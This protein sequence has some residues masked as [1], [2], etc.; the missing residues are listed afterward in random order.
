MRQRRHHGDIG[1]GLQRQVML[2]LDMRR[3]HDVGAARIDHDQLGALPQ[4]LLQPR[5]EHR[6]PVGRVGADDHHDI[7]MIDAVE[8]LGAGRGAE[9]GLQAIAGRRMADARAGVDV[10]V[11]KTLP[12]QLLDEI[13]LLVGAAR[14]GDAADRAAAMLVLDAAELAGD[15]R[16]RFFPAHFAPRIAD[17]FPDHR[18]EDAILVVRIAPGETPLHAGMA[19]IGLAVLPGHHAHHFVAA[20]FRL[21]RAA[22]AAIGAGR[23]HRMG[24]PAL[25]RARIF[26]AARRS[27][28]PARRRRRTRIP[29]R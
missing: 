28:R 29:N 15:V 2:R 10:V 27:D 24:R 9:G 21:E 6:M 8:I 13:G 25:L 1:A 3:A 16:E 4:P 14:R 17:L 19:A 12:H 7:G 23:H 26:R 20:H 5:G 11:A 18:V 22:D